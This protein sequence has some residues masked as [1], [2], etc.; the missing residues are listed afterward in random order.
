MEEK[1][2]SE[3]HGDA[4]RSGETDVVQPPEFIEI[5]L[6]DQIETIQSKASTR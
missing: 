2:C 3:R 6:L 4:G 5:R 1:V